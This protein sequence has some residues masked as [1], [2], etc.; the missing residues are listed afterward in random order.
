MLDGVHKCLF[1][2]ATDPKSVLDRSGPAAAD[3]AIGCE[4]CHGPGGNHLRAVAAKLHDPAIVNPATA[5]AEGRVRVC[6][7]CHSF[8]QQSPLPRTDLFWIRYQGTTLPWSRC[9]S[10]SGGSLDC[11]TCHDPH[12]DTD[13]SETHYNAQCLSCHSNAPAKASVSGAESPA[14]SATHHSTCPV[15]ATSGCVG[16][17]MPAIEIKP[18]H[19]TFSDHYIRVRRALVPKS[20]SP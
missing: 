11:M 15:N 18:L 7:Q 14:A 6:G 2:H 9:Y 12:H 3:R 10:E 17:H 5:P 20:L 13:R 16:C 4:R 19:T 1:C 8:H